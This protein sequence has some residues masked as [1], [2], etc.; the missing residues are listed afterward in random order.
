MGEGRRSYVS[1]KCYLFGYVFIF[2]LPSMFECENVT[3][4]SVAMFKDVINV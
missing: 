4:E 3:Y 1:F 2:E